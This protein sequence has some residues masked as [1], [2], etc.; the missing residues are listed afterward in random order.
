MHI[1]LPYI[2][3]WSLFHK[4]RT[5]LAFVVSEQAD[6]VSAIVDLEFEHAGKPVPI[7]T[8]EVSEEIEALIKR[9]ILSGTQLWV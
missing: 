1:K 3:P 9:R 7:I 5:F 8:A 2:L 6:F 4:R